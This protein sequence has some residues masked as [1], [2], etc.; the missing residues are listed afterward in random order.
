MTVVVIP[1]DVLPAVSLCLSVTPLSISCLSI[2]L[3]PF[4][5]SRRLAS[6]TV[7]HE[8][9]A[10]PSSKPRWR[11]ARCFRRGA[12]NHGRGRPCSPFPT[13]RLTTCHSGMTRT[14]PRRRT[15]SLM[16]RGDLLQG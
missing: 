1:E 11:D 13:P 12:G 5:L 4:Y 15:I 7:R 9:A 2:S 8:R 14:R 10:L 16:Y 3:T 6:V